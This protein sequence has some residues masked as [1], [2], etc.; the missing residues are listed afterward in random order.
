MG[1]DMPPHLSREARAWRSSA[2]VLGLNLLLEVISAL[3][4]QS[5]PLA[6]K[7]Q[8]GRGQGVAMSL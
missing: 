5:S 4:V 6:P 8:L 1:V 7:S 3:E 2:L